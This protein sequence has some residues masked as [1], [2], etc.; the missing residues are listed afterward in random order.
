M[1]PCHQ[2]VPELPIGKNA[3]ILIFAAGAVQ[4]ISQ[5]ARERKHGGLLVSVSA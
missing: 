4:A 1:R 2:S 3:A 5:L